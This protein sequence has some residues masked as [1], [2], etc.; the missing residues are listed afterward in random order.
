MLSFLWNTTHIIIVILN[1]LFSSVHSGVSGWGSSGNVKELLQTRKS[2]WSVFPIVYKVPHF[3]QI[4]TKRVWHGLPL[5]LLFFFSVLI[6]PKSKVRKKECQRPWVCS[7]EGLMPL[8]EILAWTLVT[9]LK[10]MLCIVFNLLE[11]ALSSFPL[12]KEHMNTLTKSDNCN[13]ILVFPQAGKWKIQ[14]LE[15]SEQH[16]ALPAKHIT[17]SGQCCQSMY[18]R[19][20]VPLRIPAP[21]LVLQN[22][23]FHS[24]QPLCSPS[25]L[26]ARDFL[27]NCLCCVPVDHDYLVFW[28]IF[29]LYKAFRENAYCKTSAYVSF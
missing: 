28:T 15:I 2:K 1:F 7:N 27:G 12:L 29:Y 23:I 20:A 10:Q 6:A 9:S 13:K 25:L 16:N 19:R 3:K 18:L 22:C 17:S 8:D 11:N 14:V 21:R 24:L 5:H 4:R 26:E